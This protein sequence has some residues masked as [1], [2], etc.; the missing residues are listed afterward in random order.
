MQS[1]SRLYVI[2]FSLVF[3]I[4]YD[5]HTVFLKHI[6]KDHHHSKE[7][8]NRKGREAQKHLLGSAEAA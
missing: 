8:A 4:K 3:A 1:L 7:H 5:E 2:R 6:I